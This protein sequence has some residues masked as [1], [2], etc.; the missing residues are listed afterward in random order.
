M[1]SAIRPRA[2]PTQA[3]STRP[4]YEHTFGNAELDLTQLPFTDSQNVTV[5]V[6]IG[7]GNLEITVPPNVDVTVDA[8]ID[9]GNAD[10]FNQSWSGLDPAPRT[11]TD[12]GPDGPGGGTL[13]INASVDA[14]N[15][16]VDR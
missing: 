13:R 6:A 14:G 10:V 8:D 16:E 7:A 3:P 12:Y 9:L 2:R 1:P 15:L 5:D 11:V 4:S